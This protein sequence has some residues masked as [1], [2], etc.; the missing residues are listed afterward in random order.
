[1]LYICLDPHSRA[2]QTEFGIIR[3]EPVLVIGGG[4]VTDV[5]GFACAAYRR[6]TNFIR[7]PTT[8]IGLIDA[9]V[10]IK[11]AVNYGNYKNRLGACRYSGI[12]P[13]LL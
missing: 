4:L 5:A 10:S 1:M 11:V 7:I 9:S 6:T 13:S 12:C 3:K 2:Q 8:V